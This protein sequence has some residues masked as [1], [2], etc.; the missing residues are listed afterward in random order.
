MFPAP[1]EHPE[2][3]SGEQDRQSSGM[4][5]CVLGAPV[6]PASQGHLLP[7][8]NCRPGEAI[9][10]R[11]QP[12][13]DLARSSLLHHPAQLELGA[14]SDH[15]M[16]RV[17]ATVARIRVA[18]TVVFLK[19]KGLRREGEP[20][21]KTATDEQKGC[22]RPSLQR[23]IVARRLI[24]DPGHSVIIRRAGRLQNEYFIRDV[25]PTHRPSSI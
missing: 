17:G 22:I 20:V 3:P 2:Q 7:L 24:P 12:R 15:E 16:R 10:M 5:P 14:F 6:A 4:F 21:R 11:A 9:D 8:K 13:D 23:T 18:D 1:E 19:A 25:E